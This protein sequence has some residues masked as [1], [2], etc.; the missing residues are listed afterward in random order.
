MPSYSAFYAYGLPLCPLFPP[1]LSYN[2]FFLDG[3]PVVNSMSRSGRIVL[4]WVAGLRCLC[5]WSGL[6]VMNA[7]V[8]RSSSLCGVF[9]IV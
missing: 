3:F 5:F 6:F 8:S 4:V 7:N 9:L 1:G 2:P